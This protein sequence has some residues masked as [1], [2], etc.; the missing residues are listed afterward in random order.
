MLVFTP[1]DDSM[2]IGGKPLSTWECLLGEDGVTVGEA[3]PRLTRTSLPGRQGVIDQT[4][5]DRTGNAYQDGRDI[6]VDIVLMADEHDQRQLKQRLGRLHGTYTSLHWPRMW[7][8]EYR[9]TLEIGE[10]ADRFVPGMRWLATGTMLTLHS[11]DGLQHARMRRHDLKEGGNRIRV[12]G[13]RPAPPTLTLTPATGATSITVTIDGVRLEYTNAKGFT[14]DRPIHID[15]AGQRTTIGDTTPLAPTVD[16][17]YPILTPRQAAIGLTG[18][19]GRIGYE[20]V[21]YI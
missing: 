1:S 9:G 18:A 12:L 19:T 11:D 15:T 2:L 4:L 7:A 6:T 5:R 8:G 16:S 13:N 14:P 17:D 3:K 21:W 10:W 20:P